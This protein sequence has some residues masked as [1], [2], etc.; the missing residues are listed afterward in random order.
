MTAMSAGE[1]VTAGSLL[2]GDHVAVVDLGQA[3][4]LPGAA[5]HDDKAVEADPDAA[6]QAAGRAVVPG[7]PPGAVPG[8]QQR[9]AD[10]LP[11]FG[12]DVGAVEGERGHAANLSGRNGV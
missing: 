9:G 10:A 1:V 12:G 4:P 8:R 5:V 7:G 3:G 2:R 6:E 11:R